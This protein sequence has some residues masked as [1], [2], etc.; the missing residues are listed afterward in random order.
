MVLCGYLKASQSQKGHLPSCLLCSSPWC[1]SRIFLQE[2]RAF[3]LL[4]LRKV[5]HKA[6]SPE[7]MNEEII[8]QVAKGHGG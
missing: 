1:P 6:V 2:G 3:V 4:K 7:G 5:Q 8:V